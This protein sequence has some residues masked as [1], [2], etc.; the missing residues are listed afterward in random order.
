MPLI[1]QGLLRGKYLSEEK[2]NN[3]TG[4]RKTEGDYYFI[5]IFEDRRRK[6]VKTSKVF[7]IS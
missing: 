7:S 4:F 3:R 6:E 1:H 2:G 5:R